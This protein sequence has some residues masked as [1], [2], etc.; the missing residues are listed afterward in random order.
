MAMGEDR[1]RRSL[2][3]EPSGTLLAWHQIDLDHHIRSHDVHFV[4]VK[5]P[6]PALIRWKL[7]RITSSQMERLAMARMGFLDKAREVEVGHV[8]FNGKHH[9]ECASVLDDGRG[10]SGG[11]ITTNPS[12]VLK[13]K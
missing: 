8:H 13:T 10:Q 4:T 11:G 7:R 2:E 1:S 12:A 5:R 9:G 6:F 3:I